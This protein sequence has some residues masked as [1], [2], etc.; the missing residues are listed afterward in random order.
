M[1]LGSG[2]RALAWSLSGVCAACDGVLPN[3][4]CPPPP[5]G[6]AGLC[7]GTAAGAAVNPSR[8]ASHDHCPVLSPAAAH[9]PRRTGRHG[10]HLRMGAVTMLMA[11]AAARAPLVAVRSC[12]PGL[13]S[14][15]GRAPS[16][17]CVAGTHGATFQATAPTF[18]CPCS[19]SV[20]VGGCASAA[21]CSSVWLDHCWRPCVDVDWS[22]WCEAGGTEA[23]HWSVSVFV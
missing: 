22:S 10:L 19:D 21:V 4:P 3:P 20:S 16:S 13:S 1:P 5:R 17:T 8:K 9:R 23:A 2:A 11:L 18:C 12:E 14:E 6:P 15:S 7:V